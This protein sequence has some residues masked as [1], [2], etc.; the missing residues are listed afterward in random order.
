VER[1]AAPNNTQAR[2]V[3]LV[4]IK[5]PKIL[6]SNGHSSDGNESMALTWKEPLAKL[7]HNAQLSFMP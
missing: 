6:R 1:P 7:L 2:T 4:A 3:A 5:R